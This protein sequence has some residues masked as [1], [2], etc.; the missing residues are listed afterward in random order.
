MFITSLVGIAS[1]PCARRGDANRSATAVYWC[2]ASH[3]RHYV[4]DHDGRRFYTWF[5]G[6]WT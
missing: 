3:S 5:D 6:M 2:T 1:A 4:G